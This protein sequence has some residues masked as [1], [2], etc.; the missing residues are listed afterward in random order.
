[1]L[2]ETALAYLSPLT[3]RADAKLKVCFVPLSGIYW[4]DEIPHL[5]H[6][7]HLPED[8]LVQILRLFGIRYRIWQSLSLTEDDRQYWNYAKSQ[9]PDCP[10]FQ[11]LKLSQD[12]QLAQNAAVKAG[13]EVEEALLADADQVSVTEKCPGVEEFSANFDLRKRSSLIGSPARKTKPWWTRIF[14]RPSPSKDSRPPRH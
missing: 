12:D 8:S 13:A 5:R 4:D 6:F 9:L 1:M 10:I 3:Y 14:S 7:M 11:R 2:N